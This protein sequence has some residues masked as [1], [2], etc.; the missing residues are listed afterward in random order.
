LVALV[1]DNGGPQFE[2]VLAAVTAREA[3]LS[4]AID[5]GVAIPHGESPLLPE[6]RLAAGT[7]A[8][9]VG[10]DARDAEPVGLFF[11][12]VGPEGAGGAHVKALSRLSRLVREE[13]FRE[14]LLTARDPGEFCRFFREGERR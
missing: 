11:L 3:V 10:F 6:L 8:E 1:A 14:Q 5:Y 9:P 2:D 4:T 7:S 13:P 12:L